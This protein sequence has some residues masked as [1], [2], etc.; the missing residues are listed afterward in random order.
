MPK[1]KLACFSMLPCLSKLA[2]H[3]CS[4][5]WC[6]QKYMHG[7]LVGLLLCVAKELLLPAAESSPRAAPGQQQLPW[8][9]SFWKTLLC[10]WK[11]MLLAITQRN[12]EENVSNELPIQK[13]HC[14]EGEKHSDSCQDFRPTPLSSILLKNWLAVLNNRNLKK[15]KC[16]SKIWAGRGGYC[17]LKS[18]R[19]N[20]TLFVLLVWIY[21]LNLHLLSRDTFLS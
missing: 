7:S 3:K 12:K 8:S 15:G 13:H 14:P 20:P 4:G 21:G 5:W 9:R 18:P 2:T 6:T 17:I 16:F 19:N 10:I 11:D 1:I